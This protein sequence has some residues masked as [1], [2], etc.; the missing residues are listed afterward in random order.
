[1][2]FFRLN[3]KR[4]HSVLL[5]VGV[6]AAIL[7][8]LL[9][10]SLHAA[11]YYVDAS[12]GQ[13]TNTGISVTTAWKTI[14]KVNS[15]G[16]NPGDKILFKRGEVWRAQ[17][18]VPSSGS[19][20]NP[21]T[22]GAYGTGNKPKILGSID[23]S[24]AG[25][26]TGEG[27]NLWYAT[28][29]LDIGSLIFNNETSIGFK[30][31]NKTDLTTQGYFWW[32]SA[33]H[34]VHVYS[35][36]NPGTY[37]T[38]IEAAQNQ[39]GIYIN[40][41]SNLTIDGLDIRYAGRHGIQVD[42]GGSSCDNITIQNN[43]ISWIGGIYLTGTIPYGNGIEIWDAATNVIVRYNRIN[44]VVDA[45]MTTQNTG[46]P[47]R[48]FS[49]HQYYYN[50]II[51]AEYGFEFACVGATMNGLYI[52]NNVFYNNTG[53]A[54]S[55]RIV[56]GSGTGLQVWSSVGLSNCVFK[57]NI[58]HTSATQH[59]KFD[60]SANL[61]AWTIDNNSYYPDGPMEFYVV[62]YSQSNFAGWK[63]PTLKDAHSIITDPLF[64]ST[65]TP[66]FHLQTGSPAINAGVDVGL[67]IDYA[68]NP[69]VGLP[70]MGA[71]EA[72]ENMPVPPE[73]LRIIP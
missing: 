23:L 45:G 16:F 38:A 58:I 13:D 19:V 46:D 26:W 21:I 32:D 65:S 12:G 49:N 29:P 18:T 40:G 42:G 15:S 28:A 17:L 48:V 34:R 51:G 36:S 30:H 41:K 71:Y 72:F 47:G 70:D 4:V 39:H 60:N 20:G 33:N 24:A 53:W 59:I 43:D 63:S 66:D 50:I 44:Q 27:G 54:H 31:P 6:L 62:S 64:V 67:T 61:S 35:A 7:L 22:F 69:I 9:A 52:Y 11:T 8:T 3:N 55:Q 14:V 1:M 10:P 5:V 25:S 73:N 57:N 56:Y 68:G 37:Y 2:T